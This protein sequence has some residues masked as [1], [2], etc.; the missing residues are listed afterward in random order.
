MV[1]K[2][3][4]TK[5]ITLS[6]MA[7]PKDNVKVNKP[8]TTEVDTEKIDLGVVNGAD[9]INAFQTGDMSKL[10]ELGLDKEETEKIRLQMEQYQKESRQKQ[11]YS[12][13]GE[14]FQKIYEKWPDEHIL[15]SKDEPD[16][17]YEELNNHL[18][19]TVM[20]IMEDEMERV[21]NTLAEKVKE[22]FIQ[23][24]KSPL[25]KYEDRIENR[26]GKVDTGIY[27]VSVPGTNYYTMNTTLLEPLKDQNIEDRFVAYKLLEFIINSVVLKTSMLDEET[28]HKIL[29]GLANSPYLLD[30]IALKKI[31]EDMYNTAI[32][33]FEK[34]NLNDYIEYAKEVLDY[35][36]PKS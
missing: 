31:S 24:R 11:A 28:R 36:F 14:V 12:L 10:S 15:P 26:F 6:D 1:E 13:L 8:K 22:I 7:R 34:N 3:E 5:I 23:E 16:F 25:V 35:C 9:I 29:I 33:V 32:Y 2:D 21:Y 18:L 30:S 20:N 4:N 17:I 27:D 19:K